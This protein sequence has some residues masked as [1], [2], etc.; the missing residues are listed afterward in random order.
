VAR[1]YDRLAKEAL[2]Q[3]LGRASRD[4][5]PERE[6]AS[7]AQRLDLWCVPDPERLDSLEPF[8]LLRRIAEQGPCAFEFF[9]QAPSLDEIVS[10]LRKGFF[11]RH[12]ARIP[13]RKEEPWLWIIAG[14][15]PSL[16]LLELDFRREADW[17]DG[18]YSGARALRARLIVTSELPRSEETRLLRLLGA[19]KTLRLA[20]GELHAKGLDDPV[21]AIVLPL[22]VRLHLDRLNYP[23]E[24]T[25]A[26]TQ[27]FL[28]DTQDVYERWHTKIR[29][30]GE[31]VGRAE[32]EAVGRAEGEARALLAVL[33]ARGLS[34]STEQ[35][36]LISASRDLEQ[37]ESWVRRAATASNTDEVFRPP[38]G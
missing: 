29:A 19:G 3:A 34:P 23:H 15:R 35:L 22:M 33:A 9:H 11:L 16:A 4:L 27:E 36:A 10:S 30:E 13:P 1:L 5:V 37:L 12:P 17:P 8:G 32:G 21:G 7:D 18:V 25:D 6:L 2:M 24:P 38:T 20:K 31:A 26:E 28:M 14:G